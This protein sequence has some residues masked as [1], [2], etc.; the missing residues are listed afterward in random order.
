[1]SLKHLQ[2]NLYS[3]IL[4]VVRSP[5]CG[6]GRSRRT[7]R[8]LM[9]TMQLQGVLASNH[10]EMNASLQPRLLAGRMSKI[11]ACRGLRADC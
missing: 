6:R 5:L 10:A 1:M 9:V 11:P 3:V 7:P 4:S 8:I 2:M